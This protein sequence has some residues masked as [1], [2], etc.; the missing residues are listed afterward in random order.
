MTDA[1]VTP[2][3]PVTV[4]SATAPLVATAEGVRGEHVVVPLN[5]VSKARLI[6]PR[7]VVRVQLTAGETDALCEG[8]FS[9]PLPIMRAEGSTVTLEYPGTW[10]PLR[11]PQPSRITLNPSV[12]WDIEMR[13]ANYLVA[14]LSRVD[15]LS[16][17]LEGS[18]HVD[19]VLTD[20]TAL[21]LS[22]RAG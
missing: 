7:D 6:F 21:G 22:R 14:D 5:G 9:R 12:A 10:F 16:F 15:L 17:R 4:R 11:Q 1:M 13:N 20:R 2:K 19:L 3:H 8:F 18:E